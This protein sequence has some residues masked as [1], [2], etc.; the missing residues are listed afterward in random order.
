MEGTLQIEG[1]TDEQWTVNILRLQLY[2]ITD[3][4]ILFPFTGG[5]FGE[6]KVVK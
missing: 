3:I 6:G 5:N 2:L 4:C 1:E